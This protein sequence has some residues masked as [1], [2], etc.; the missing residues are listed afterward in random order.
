MKPALWISN[1]TFNRRSRTDR[2]AVTL[3]EMV[4]VITMLSVA[5][6]AMGM[7]LHGVW[8]VQQAMDER[9]LTLDALQRLATQFRSDVHSAASAAIR[10]GNDASD[11]KDVFTLTLPGGKQI[12][13]QVAAGS[14]GRTL[15]EGEKTL[16][17][18]SYVLPVAAVVKWEISTSD[19][20]RQQSG[21]Q[22][23]LL[24]SYPRSSRLP[25]FSDRREL[26]IDAVAGSQMSEIRLS[27]NQP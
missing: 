1:R 17:R 20:N 25:E 21:W 10:T 8:R 14:V 16:A 3:V 6:A 13:Y 7:L 27:E 24:V 23:S 12:D 2:R 19:L 15:R 22:A 18:E 4:V 5:M 26:R 11:V 9:C